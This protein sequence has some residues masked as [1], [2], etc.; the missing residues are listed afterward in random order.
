M[1]SITNFTCVDTDNE[2]SNNTHFNELKRPNNIPQM[3]YVVVSILAESY[4]S[5]GSICNPFNKY[6]LIGIENRKFELVRKP[7]DTSRKN[8]KE[9]FKDSNLLEKLILIVAKI[10]YFVTFG[11]LPLIAAIFAIINRI[12]HKPHFLPKVSDGKIIEI[13]KELQGNI[14]LNLKLKKLDDTDVDKMRRILG[15]S[16]LSKI[17]TLNLSG[18]DLTDEKGWKYVPG[19]E[20]DYLLRQI[21]LMFPKLEELY[22]EDPS[23]APVYSYNVKDINPKLITTNTYG[24][25]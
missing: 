23:K 1:Y 5:N 16:T 2:H 15:T 9:S 13:Y 10:S 8:F 22:I 25:E 20:K 4:L 21:C 7:L 14:A 12:I 11:I 19:I 3:I 6:D 18:I 24:G 17:K